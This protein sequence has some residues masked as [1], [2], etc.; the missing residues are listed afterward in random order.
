MKQ[1]LMNRHRGPG[2]PALSAALDGAQLVSDPSA[3]QALFARCP[4]ADVTPLVALEGVA[5]SLGI[6][7]VIA[8]DERGRMGLG[9]F[10]ALGAAHAIAKRAVA[11][12]RSETDE[13]SQ[14]LAGETFVCASAG[15]HGVSVAAGARVFGA[16]AVIYLS[17]AVPDAFAQQLRAKGA[18]VV[19]E[20]TDY[21]TSMA[22][23]M[24]TAEREGWRLLSDST[25]P[26]YMDPACDVM[27]GYLVMAAEA[28][29][30]LEAPPTHIFLQAG[31]GG[32]AAACTAMA[33]RTWGDAPK[34]CVV[35]PEYAPA[36]K[37][38]IDAGRS[39][40]AP[41][42]TSAMGRLD[43]KEPSLLALDVLARDADAFMTVNEAAAADAVALLREHDL[44]SSPSGVAGFA[45]L[46][47]A[48]RSEDDRGDLALDA[49]SRVLIYIS[50]GDV[51]A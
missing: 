39:V 35:E 24:A 4:S 13:L 21:E 48:L 27:E 15:N 3:A 34:I 33:R 11:T 44:P 17:E 14:A 32:L 43:C 46:V 36:L 28:A 8:K 23:A 1:I 5:E 42:P 45:G 18:D 19:V 51:D 30:Q 40:V 12:A 26:G 31:V 49:Q 47:E 10:K 20:G 6:A 50:E 16:R 29:E 41:G 38:S 37:A 25:W 7:A 9:S 22:A 2:L